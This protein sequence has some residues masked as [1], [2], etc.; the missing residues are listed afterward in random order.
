MARIAAQPLEIVQL[1]LAALRERHD[2]IALAI[3]RH[4]PAGLTC[5]LVPALDCLYQPAPWPAAS[6][7]AP[8]ADG[9]RVALAS[10]RPAAHHR[11]PLNPSG[12]VSDCGGSPSSPS[13]SLQY[14][15]TSAS[16]SSASAMRFR[17]ADNSCAAL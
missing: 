7:P 6:A 12:S 10:L 3:L 2:V 14:R 17:A 16:R 8:A 11:I 13:G 15:Y 9:L 1:R 5:V 4:P